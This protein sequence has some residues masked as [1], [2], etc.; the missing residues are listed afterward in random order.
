M[1]ANSTVFEN[2]IACMKGNS[3]KIQKF[4][5]YC[6]WCCVDCSGSASV[7][8]PCISMGLIMRGKNHLLNILSQSLCCLAMK[9]FKCC[10]ATLRQSSSAAKRQH[11]FQRSYACRFE[12]GTTSF[13][14]LTSGVTSLTQDYGH[15][16]YRLQFGPCVKLIFYPAVV[17]II[18]I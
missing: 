2:V 14:G 13:Q 11:A 9:F 8:S 5:G 15:I 4:S 17:K 3:G 7:A 10:V 6:L 12:T 1:V 16:F 18:G